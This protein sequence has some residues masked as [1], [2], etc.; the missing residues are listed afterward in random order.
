VK[1]ALAVLDSQANITFLSR[2]T[3]L[4]LFSFLLKPEEELD[5]KLSL[6]TVG[7]DSLIVIENWW[8][9][10]LGFDMTIL[11]ILAAGSSEFER[12]TWKQDCTQQIERIELNVS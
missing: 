3:G 12:F 7:V 8:K 2:E 10:S 1:N 11:E 4:R 5:I 9:H 6:A